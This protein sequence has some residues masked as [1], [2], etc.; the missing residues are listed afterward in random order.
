VCYHWASYADLPSLVAVSEMESESQLLSM[1]RRNIHV[2]PRDTGWALRREGNV[3]P[4]SVYPTQKDAVEAARRIAINEQSEMVIHGRD[5]RIRERD[6]YGRDPYPPR[7][8]RRVLLPK[9]ASKTDRKKIEKAV[10]EV[11]QKR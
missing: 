5:G 10:D 3:R 6:S 7:E 1:S 8:T 11:T 9:T 4:T 2:V